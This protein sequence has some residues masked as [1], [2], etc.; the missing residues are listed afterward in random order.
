[1]LRLQSACHE[2][3][4][5]VISTR[6][7]QGKGRSVEASVARWRSGSATLEGLHY[8]GVRSPRRYATARRDRRHEL[9]GRLGVKAFSCDS[10]ANVTWHDPC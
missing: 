2:L 10:E 7:E 1:M 8:L 9:L 5:Q 6:H 3:K 4:D